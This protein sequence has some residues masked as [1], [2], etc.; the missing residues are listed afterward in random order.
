VSAAIFAELTRL[1]ALTSAIQSSQSNGPGCFS[2]FIVAA[3]ASS[4]TPALQ[5]FQ[6]LLTAQ[7]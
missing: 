2:G 4:R 3:I 1:L 7:S 6:S 5:F